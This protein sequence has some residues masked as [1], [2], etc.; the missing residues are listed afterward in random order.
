MPIVNGI[1][2]GRLLFD[3]LKKCIAYTLSSNIPEMVPFLFFI[4][5]QI[6]LPISTVL[7]L[8]IDLLFDTVP[9]YSFAYE[10]RELDIMQRNPRN[11]T[12]DYLV[13]RKL[14]SFS[15]LQIGMI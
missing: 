10:N 14:I 1:E 9:A 7:V 5:L 2:E 13:N 6:P 3:N 8:C 11:V 4:L 12:R 15:Y